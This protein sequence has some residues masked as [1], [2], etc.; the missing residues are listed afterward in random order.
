MF[1][2][3]KANRLVLYNRGGEVYCAVRTIPDI[4][5]M[6][7]VFKE[8]NKAKKSEQLNDLYCSP[9]IVRVIKSR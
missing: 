6:F 9:N 1:A 4:N 7:F 2:L 3:Y 8:F 5:S